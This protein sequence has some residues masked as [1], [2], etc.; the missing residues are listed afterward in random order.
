ML[1]GYNTNVPY[2]GRLYH[3]Q[4][5]DNGTSNPV[6]VTLLYIKGAIL[7]SRRT[8]YAH[9]LSGPHYKE[10]V[11]EMMKE[12][13]KSMIRELIRGVHTTE[14]AE[15]AETAEEVKGAGQATPEGPDSTKDPA[16]SLDDILIDYIIK[17]GH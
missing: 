4:T 10:A 17:G 9:L 6:I 8:S 5:E 2:K 14:E 1:V 16:K 13:H 7:A 12:Q 3:V 11:R 15:S